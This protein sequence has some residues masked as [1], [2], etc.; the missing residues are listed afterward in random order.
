MLYRL[1]FST[2]LAITALQGLNGLPFGL[3]FGKKDRQCTTF[4]GSITDRNDVWR[5]EV[6]KENLFEKNDNGVRLKLDA[7]GQYET[8]KND[9]ENYNFNTKVGSGPT[10][11]FIPQ[12]QYG[13]VSATIQA[14][15]APGSVTALIFKSTSGDEIDY[16]LLSGPDEAQTNYYWG[17][18]VETGVN[19]DIEK[20]DVSSR[21]RKYTIDWTPD[22]IKWSID[23]ELIRTVTK[24]ETDGKFPENPSQIQIGLW[25]GSKEAG[26][27]RWA[28]GPIDVSI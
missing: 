11:T 7:P 13:K 6:D 19:G 26:T 10:F 9:A 2:L 21:P 23:D 12:I 5:A 20:T 17:K 3:D 14:P 24:D 25:D 18:K 15:E 8:Q 4:Q 28:H 16:E 27:A 22:Y 1:A